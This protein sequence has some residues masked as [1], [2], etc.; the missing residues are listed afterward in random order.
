MEPLGTSRSNPATAFFLPK[1]LDN[2]RTSIAGSMRAFLRS[3][4]IKGS[5]PLFAAIGFAIGPGQFFFHQLSD[6]FRRQGTGS[7]LAERFAATSAHNLPALAPST[8]WGV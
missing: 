2:P 8:A 6:L 1:C 5:G 7:C 4:R 3:W